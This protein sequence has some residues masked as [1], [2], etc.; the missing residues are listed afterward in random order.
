MSTRE[1]QKSK[2]WPTAKADALD[3]P[4]VAVVG[5]VTIEG[6]EYPNPSTTQRLIARLDA[7]HYPAGGYESRMRVIGQELVPLARVLEGVDL[8][9]GD[10][11]LLAWLLKSDA[12]EELVSLIAKIRKTP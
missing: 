7:D 11:S 12:T 2:Y 10:I 5:P 4:A 3:L 9:A 1:Q 8:S 6:I